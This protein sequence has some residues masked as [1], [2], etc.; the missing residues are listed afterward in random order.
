MDEK[1]CLRVTFRLHLIAGWAFRIVNNMQKKL[2]ACRANAQ[3]PLERMRSM[4]RVPT[5][6]TDVAFG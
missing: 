3:K 4:G 1:C 2:P 5:S 6:T